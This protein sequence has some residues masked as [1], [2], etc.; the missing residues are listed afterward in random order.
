MSGS[1]SSLAIAATSAVKA[2][3]NSGSTAFTFTVT[4]SGATNQASTADWAVTSSGA[5]QAGASDFT[6]SALPSGIVTFAPGETSKVV[7]VWVAGDSV[8][9]SDE[10]FAVTLSN[11]S[12][13]TAIS[14]ASATGT[15]QNDDALYILY[16]DGSDKPKSFEDNAIIAFSVQRGGGF[17]VL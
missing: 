3:G 1:V 7:T 14:A 15:I 5:N 16:Y 17:D 4:R 6:N 2:E 12:A 10:G 9:E 11:A 13:G 8:V